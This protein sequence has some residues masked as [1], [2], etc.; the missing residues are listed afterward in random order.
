MDCR[1]TTPPTP[2]VEP[3]QVATGILRCPA[4][5]QL[6]DEDTLEPITR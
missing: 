3:E 4:C 1:T 2:D 6:L 5:G